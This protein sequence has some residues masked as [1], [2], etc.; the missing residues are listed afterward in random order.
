MTYVYVG[1]NEQERYG[2]ELRSFDR[3]AFS[4]AF[5]GGAVTIYEVDHSELPDSG[6]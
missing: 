5:E 3:E 2:S 4:I 6:E 1:P